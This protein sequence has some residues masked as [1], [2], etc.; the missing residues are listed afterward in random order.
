MPRFVPLKALREYWKC[1]ITTRRIRQD[2]GTPAN[3]HEDG[4]ATGKISSQNWLNTAEQDLTPEVLER[5][6][7]I[8]LQIEDLTTEKEALSKHLK[9]PNYACRRASKCPPACSMPLRR[10]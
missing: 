6:A 9:Q 3:S 2:S 8:P 4:R 1:L 5:V 7:N 10:R